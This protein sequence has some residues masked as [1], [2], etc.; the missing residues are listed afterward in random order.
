[1]TFEQKLE[2][3]LN[4][5]ASVYNLNESQIKIIKSSI[6][7]RNIMYNDI[8]PSINPHETTIIKNST[9]I[10]D[11]LINRLINN[12]RIYDLENTYNPNETDKGTYTA[13]V[14]KINIKSYQT[15]NTIHQ[16]QLQRRVNNIDN[17]M[18][19]KANIKVFNHEIG[20]ALQHSFSGTNGTNNEK[21]MQVV[22]NLFSKYPDFFQQPVNNNNMI[23]LQKG[24][25]PIRKNDKKEQIRDF[26]A[27]HP[28]LTHLDEIFNE[29]ESLKLTGISKPQFLYDMG[30]GFYKKIYNY[31]SRNS[32]ITSYASMMKII[33]G[34]ERTYRA[35][36]EDS[37]IAFE[38]FDQFKEYSDSILKS[39]AYYK[40]ASM[41]NILDYFEQIHNNNSLQHCLELDLFFTVCLQ[42]KI[43]HELNNTELNEN[44]LSRM[45]KYIDDFVN[46]MTINPNL[47]T[48]QDI[49][50]EELK[51]KINLKRQELIQKKDSI[52][53]KRLYSH[54]KAKEL[55][56][57]EKLKQI[58]K[59]NNDEVGYN[60]A[61]TN[62]ERIIREYPASV[63]QEEWNKMTIDEKTSFVKVKITEAKI[64][65]DKK[66]FDY[67]NQSLLSLQKTPTIVQEYN[68]SLYDVSNF[69]QNNTNNVVQTVAP[70]NILTQLEDKI[71]KINQ[72]NK[73]DYKYYYNEIIKNIKKI[74]SSSNLSDTE[75]KQIVGDIYYNIEYLIENLKTEE[76]YGI[77]L[78]AITNDFG[79][80]AFETNITKAIIQDMIEK[81]PK[82]SKK[83][84]KNKEQ[85]NKPIDNTAMI[86][87]LKKE[88]MKLQ[89]QYDNAR[90]DGY[91]DDDELSVLMYRIKRLEEEAYR[92]KN[93]TRGTSL[94]K[95]VISIINI[96]EDSQ[97]KMA[98]RESIEDEYLKVTKR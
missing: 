5:I 11:V 30:N 23:P 6:T 98:K 57:L 68:S 34:E 39:S 60:Y 42:K 31:E 33:M 9:T 49:I 15:V 20:H 35:M 62:I 96:I 63:S 61:Q 27:G 54:P 21:F 38:F 75:K 94:E 70:N 19:Y 65:K 36:Y 50:I 64:L 12:I 86:N 91:I 79:N 16:T 2:V 25:K 82:I 4:E 76:E 45:S 67:W 8:T 18:L 17:E 43:I 93:K 77:I 55:N 71:E 52:S 92:L 66:M 47:K 41:L 69:Q 51:N 80:D 48:K 40:K 89:R 7:N 24:M 44:D 32:K 78:E 73:K 37:I 28:Y 13:N 53:G 10:G 74:R 14:Q 90:E 1:M 95:M 26:Y 59:Q 72:E 81:L 29:E 88:L 85:N 46:Q 97:I 56:E 3:V 58:S 22:N 84:K 83:S 87:D